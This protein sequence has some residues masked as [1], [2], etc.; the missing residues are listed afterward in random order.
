MLLV[1]GHT[2]IY[3]FS[4]DKCVNCT[5]YHRI[6]F[7]IFITSH[8]EPSLSVSQKFKSSLNSAKL[9]ALIVLL[10]GYVQYSYTLIWKSGTYNFFIRIYTRTAISGV[11]WT[12][13]SAR[14]IWSKSIILDSA[15]AHH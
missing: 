15:V 4:T 9:F 1:F 2:C 13:P 8:E 6:Q 12:R 7:G 5:P 11:M 3:I 10:R 14:E